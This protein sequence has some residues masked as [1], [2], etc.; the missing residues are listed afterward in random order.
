MN[1]EDESPSR[2]RSGNARRPASGQTQGSNR[3]SPMPARAPV[4]EPAAPP[5][6]LETPLASRLRSLRESRPPEGYQEPAAIP[7]FNQPFDLPKPSLWERVRR[8][9]GG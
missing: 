8:F 9:F 4:E 2:L 6:D 1:M 7:E 5:P 3:Y